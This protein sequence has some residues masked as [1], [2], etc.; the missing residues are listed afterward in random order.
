MSWSNQEMRR[1]LACLDRPRELARSNLGVRLQR[2]TGIASVR[3]AVLWLLNKTFEDPTPQNRL[4]HAIIHKSDFEGKKGSHVASSL[5][6]STRT[7][8]RLRADAIAALAWAAEQ[9]EKGPEPRSNF[10]YEVS[11]MISPVKPET[12]ADL[13]ERE[14]GRVGARAA[15]EAVCSSARNGHDVPLSVL[16]KC[17]GHWRLLAELEIARTKLN[18]GDPERY[19]A[20]RPAIVDALRT[21]TEPARTRVEFELAYVDRLNSL[22]RCDV[23]ASADATSRMLKTAGADLRL[24]ALACVCQAEQACDEGDLQAADDLVKELQNMC[25]RLDDFRVYARTAHVSSILNLLEGNYAEACDLCEVTIA[26]LGHLEPEFAACAAALEGRADLFLNRAW[27]RPHD[28][29]DRFPQSYVTA[30]LDLVWARHVATADP[31]RALVVA[32]RAAAAAM[33][34]NARG[35]LAYANGT[36]AIV[37]EFLGRHEEARR[38]RLL[39]WEQGVQLQRPFYLYDLLVHP[40]LPQRAIGTFAA[41]E[42]V[43][44]MFTRRLIVLLGICDTR[45]DQVNWAMAVMQQCLNHALDRREGERPAP[46][47]RDRAAEFVQPLRGAAPLQREVLMRCL[48]QLAVETA[49]CLLPAQR[50][51]F[52]ARFKAAASDLFD[53]MPA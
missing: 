24:Q 50:D 21:L 16:E 12:A 19:Q 51:K 39:S 27:D 48:R 13:L 34:Q 52:V 45:A 46:L 40:K 20:R 5:N 18:D 25:L 49:Y 17:T 47:P 10:K 9:L 35:T 41:D 36:L 6:I 53:A 30:M 22:R 31:K 7:F 44:V 43:L 32:E 2:A 29:C 38:Q 15:Y 1:L 26:A 11:R 28:L 3:E 14:A 8:F 4:L 37:Y 23:V 42:A 33:S